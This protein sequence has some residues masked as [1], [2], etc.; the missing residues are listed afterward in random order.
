[1]NQKLWLYFLFEKEVFNI[2]FVFSKSIISAKTSNKTSK[3]RMNM[4]F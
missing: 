3:Y 2:L 1:M 4:R